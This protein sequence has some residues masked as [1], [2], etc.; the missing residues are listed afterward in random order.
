MAYDRAD[1]HY[2]GDYPEGLPIEN[3]GTHIGMFIAWSIHRGLSGE[4][5]V[6]EAS[7]EVEAVKSR[8]MTGREFLLEVC[9]EKFWEDNLSPEG[10]EFAKLYYERDI[11]LKDYERV[12]GKGLP[13]LYHVKDTWENFDMLCP[14]IDERFRTWKAN[15][16]RLWWQFWK[17]RI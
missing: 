17:P 11:Y 6:N 5:F 4:L 1:W 3:G 12:L 14:A 16:N 8:R 2:A 7:G 9:D 13:S 15:K 10:N